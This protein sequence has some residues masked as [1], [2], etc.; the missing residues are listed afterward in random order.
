MPAITV[1]NMIDRAAAIADQHDDFV[2][3]EQWLAW[4][5]AEVRALDIF[6]ARNG[7]IQQGPLATEVTSAPYSAVLPAETMCV[8]GVWEVDG[9]RYR[10]L[11]YSDTVSSRFQ[12]PT[13]G[14]IVGAAREF[15]IE[16]N[17][18]EMTVRLFPRPTSGAYICL[19]I[20]STLG[21]TI[22]ADVLNYPLGFDEL[23]VLKLARKA[24][25]KEESNTSAV[26]RLIAQEEQRI[27]EICWNSVLAESPR[28]R[29][30]ERSGWEREPLYPEARAWAW[31]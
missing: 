24:L 13:N 27:E 30:A 25:V 18:D 20:T 21:V 6:L 23:I 26:E 2:T 12:N 3:P 7:W 10:R 31:V 16:R 9:G 5:N 1:Q 22:L 15:W 17:D 11:R 8:L 29:R 19:S 14:P 28:V 4:V